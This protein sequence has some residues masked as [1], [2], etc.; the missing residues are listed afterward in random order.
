MFLNLD[1]QWRKWRQKTRTATTV[2]P[3][4]LSD[5]TT[6]SHV[7]GRVCCSGSDDSSDNENEAEDTEED[8][9]ES[10]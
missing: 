3:G 5:K 7:V 8:L 6:Y 4:L 9:D 1:F 2:T 10:R